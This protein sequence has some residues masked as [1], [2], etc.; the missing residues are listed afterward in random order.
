MK[1]IGLKEA[2]SRLSEFVDA[3]Q[4]DRIL[5][6]RRG[7]PAALVIGVEGQDIEQVVLGNDAEFWRM[8]QERRKRSN[9]TMTSDEIRHSFGLDTTSERLRRKKAKRKKQR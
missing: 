8:I 1:M 6:T 9:G 4:R 3:A 5:I 2:K 7:E